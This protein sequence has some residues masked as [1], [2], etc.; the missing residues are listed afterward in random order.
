MLVIL[1]VLTFVVFSTLFI[2]FLYILI[3]ALILQMITANWLFSSMTAKIPA[4]DL[5]QTLTCDAV[6]GLKCLDLENKE[7]C[8]N[9]EISFYCFCEEVS[10]PPPHVSCKWCWDLNIILDRYESRLGEVLFGSLICALD[11]V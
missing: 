2:W 9:Y 8:Y 10:T 11:R 1:I 5:N 3:F 7:N 6:E 4:A